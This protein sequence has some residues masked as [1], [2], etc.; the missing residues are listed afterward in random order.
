MYVLFTVALAVEGIQVLA[1]LKFI[2]AVVSFLRD[3]TRPLSEG[4]ATDGAEG[5]EDEE[6]T[7]K[8]PPLHHHVSMAT[9]SQVTLDDRESKLSVSVKVLRPL[10]ALLEDA[11]QMNTPALVCQ[12]C[13]QHIYYRIA[14]K[15]GGN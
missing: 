6:E 15:F 11:R 2:E 4:S 13:S 12:V 14:G 7:R 8:G 1:N 10:I 9:E 5:E 3:S